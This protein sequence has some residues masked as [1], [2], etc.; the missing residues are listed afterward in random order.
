M[1]NTKTCGN[2]S[3]QGDYVNLFNSF[4]IVKLEMGCF[5]D[6]NEKGDI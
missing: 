1:S 4:A 5:S 3:G 6:M 2:L